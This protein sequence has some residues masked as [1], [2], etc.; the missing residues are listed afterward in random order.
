VGIFSDGYPGLT[1]SGGIATYTR[2]LTLGLMELGHEVQL[3][4]S[5]SKGEPDRVE[6]DG[7][8]AHLLPID[9]LPVVERF[10][11]G[12]S[13]SAVVSARARWLAFRHKLDIFEFPNWEGRGA[14][15]NLCRL[16]TPMVV[17]INTS[18]RET[19]EIE[20]AV[21][22]RKERFEANLEKRACLAADAIYVSTRA[23]RSVIAAELGISESRMSIVPL[24]LPEASIVVREPRPRNVAPVVLFLGRLEARKGVTELLEAAR[25][26]VAQMP[27]VRF[28][29]IGRDRPQAPAGVTHQQW[30]HD[31]FPP[32]VADR[33]EFLG[34]QPDAV[35]QDWFRQADLFVAPS[36]YESFGLVFVEAMRAAVP[37]ISTTAGGI[38]EVVTSG[39]SG[40]L[41]EPQQPGQIAEAILT[42]LRDEPKRIALARGARAEYESRFSN[43][44]MATRTID[45]HR[46]LLERLPNRGRRR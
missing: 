34:V 3:L 26:V 33:L 17:R 46:A 14:F 31:N 20:G 39:H 2:A 25:M 28:V 5:V 32:D 44:V 27:N 35:V 21:F 42:L 37:V 41:V 1:G 29:L 43:I 10:L 13:Q 4:I 7:V 8:R 18:L 23:H 38:A 45:Q 40:L 24:G 11:P 19:M 36:R 30:V 6:L 16:G 22:G 9:Y 12:A 15:Y